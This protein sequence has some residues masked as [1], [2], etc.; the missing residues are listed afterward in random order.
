MKRA[1]VGSSVGF[2]VGKSGRPDKSQR[3]GFNELSPL[4]RKCQVPKT[5]ETAGEIEGL[6]PTG[7]LE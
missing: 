1:I 4:C 2:S 7:G 6:R 3:H 5:E